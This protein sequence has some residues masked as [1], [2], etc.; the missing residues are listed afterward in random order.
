MIAIRICED[1]IVRNMEHQMINSSIG[2]YNL[3][4]GEH[5][6]KRVVLSRTLA[7]CGNK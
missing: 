5:L 6:R 3:Q 4:A 2:E 7:I 1:K